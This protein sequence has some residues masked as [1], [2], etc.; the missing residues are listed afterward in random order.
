M[1]NTTLKS[2]V[3]R[4]VADWVDVNGVIL[5]D[6]MRAEVLSCHKS[7]SNEKKDQWFFVVR[8]DTSRYLSSVTCYL[9]W[10]KYG[11]IEQ[12]IN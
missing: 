4:N 11:I 9:R 1:L 6:K 3:S 10:S 12:N 5:L 8:D 7:I 2:I